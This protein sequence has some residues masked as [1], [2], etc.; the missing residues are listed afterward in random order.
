[1][2]LYV[3]RDRTDCYVRKDRSGKGIQAIR[4]PFVRSVLL[5]V[6]YYGLQILCR[7][8]RLQGPYRIYVHRSRTSY[9]VYRDPTDYTSTE[10]VQ[11]K[12]PRD[13]NPYGVPSFVQCCYTSTETVR[14]IRDGEP[15]TSISTFTQLINSVVLL[16]RCFTATEPG[17]FFKDGELMTSTSSFKQR[18]DS[19]C[20][21]HSKD[22][23][24]I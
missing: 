19:D 12:R 17:F 14:T 6:Y 18:L 9:Y 23:I 2:L 8:L 15:R 5:Y 7:L 4:C 22:R 10:T 13:P 3:H 20:S 24:I 1:M 11:T 16:Q 21:V